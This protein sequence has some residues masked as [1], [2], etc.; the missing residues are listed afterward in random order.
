ML[1][2]G[3][4]CFISKCSEGECPR[5][6]ESQDPKLQGD[7]E[8]IVAGEGER[9]GDRRRY[10]GGQGGKYCGNGGG[11]CRWCAGGQWWRMGTAF[12]GSAARWWGKGLSCTSSGEKPLF[13]CYLDLCF[14]GKW[15][16][17]DGLSLC[18]VSLNDCLLIVFVL[19]VSF[20]KI[21]FFG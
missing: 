5:T 21:S 19:I 13:R 10:G 4:I 9:S 6:L 2:K 1:K 12:N 15:R 11:G 18:F 17:F 3:Y 7:K 8:G 14:I 16:V 20:L